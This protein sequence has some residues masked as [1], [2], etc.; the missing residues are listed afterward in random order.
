MRA[1][2]L[3][4]H[5]NLSAG[6]SQWPSVPL[7]Y[8]SQPQGADWIPSTSITTKRRVLL[9]VS[10]A[11]KHR[12]S[13][14]SAIFTHSRRLPGGVRLEHSLAEVVRAENR[15]LSTSRVGTLN[16]NLHRIVRVRARDSP[17]LQTNVKQPPSRLY[18]RTV[19]S[20]STPGS[21]H[22]FIRTRRNIVQAGVVRHSL[23]EIQFQNFDSPPCVE[24]MPQRRLHAA[25][26][27]ARRVKSWNWMC[28]KNA[29]TH[30]YLRARCRMRKVDG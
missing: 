6:I 14:K 17:R 28:W 23:G 12:T 15:T 10:S 8:S 11:C 9:T 13:D 19:P 7:L 20:G 30:R 25:K 3:H 16:P 18:V 21:G 2:T 5:L 1:H 24:W 29:H 22:R 4:S 27:R 26:L